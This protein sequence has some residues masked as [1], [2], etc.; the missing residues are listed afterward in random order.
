MQV[1]G[2]V[3]NV[4]PDY[5]SIMQT[6]TQSLELDSSIAANRQ[7]ILNELYTQLS[8][9]LQGITTKQDFEAKAKQAVINYAKQVNTDQYLMNLKQNLETSRADLAKLKEKNTMLKRK[10]HARAG[11]YL[12]LGFMGCAGQLGFFAGMIYGIYDWNTME[13]VTWMFCKYLPFN[14]SCLTLL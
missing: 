9:D 2:K 6:K 13:P 14:Q 10:A 12:G 11:M 5:R 7:I 1:N 8:K 4:Y 3:Y